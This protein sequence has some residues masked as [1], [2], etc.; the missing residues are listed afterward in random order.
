[1]KRA[2]CL[3]LLLEVSNELAIFIFHRSENHDVQPHLF[4]TYS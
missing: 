4:V 1:M 2:S 3:Y